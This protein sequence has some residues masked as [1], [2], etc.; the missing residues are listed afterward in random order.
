[1]F[2]PS[3]QLVFLAR[4]RQQDLLREA[5]QYRQAK[6]ALGSSGQ[7]PFPQRALRWFGRQLSRLQRQPAPSSPVR[8]RAAARNSLEDCV[9]C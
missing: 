5:S 6:L 2:I 8:P 3:W 9:S 4:E 7:V 1:M